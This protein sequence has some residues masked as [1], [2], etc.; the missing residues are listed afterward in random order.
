MTE[1]LIRA[2]IHHFTLLNIDESVEKLLQS[3]AETYFA[4]EITFAFFPPHAYI[5]LYMDTY[6]NVRYWHTSPLICAYLQ[7]TVWL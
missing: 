5:L 6:D 3:F 2:K 1:K 7:I 4:W